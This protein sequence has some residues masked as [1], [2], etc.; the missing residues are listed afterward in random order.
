MTVF[1]TDCDPIQLEQVLMDLTVILTKYCTVN[2]LKVFND[3]EEESRYEYYADDDDVESSVEESS[4]EEP[5][6]EEDQLVALCVQLAAFLLGCAAEFQFQSLSVKYFDLF[7]NLLQSDSLSIRIVSGECISLIVERFGDEFLEHYSSNTIL[8]LERQ[9]ENL[10]VG[11][12][13]YRCKKD[14]R[15]QRSA[16]RDILYT[17]QVY[18]GGGDIGALSAKPGSNVIRFGIERLS[19]DTWLYEVYYAVFRRALGPALNSHLG[20]FENFYQKN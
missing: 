12:S 18:C 1:L 9:L 13:K 6:P 15:K 7:V 5:D 16:F 3:F 11:G 4:D 10:S 20:M 2:E 19:L 8:T 17:V 14:L